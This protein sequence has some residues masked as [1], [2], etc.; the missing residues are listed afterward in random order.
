MTV[1]KFIV[2]FFD[3]IL[4]TLGVIVI[5]GLFAYGVERLYVFLMGRT[6]GRQSIFATA[7]IGVPIHELGHAA[8]C[9]VFGHR[10]TEIKLFNP[11]AEDGVFG[12]VKHRYNARNLYHQ[13]G[14][15][16]IG[17]GPIFSGVFVSSL[18]MLIC[19]RGA[20]VEYMGSVTGALFGTE[21]I[22]GAILH[23]LKMPI[24]MIVCDG[25]WWLKTSL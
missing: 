24:T 23:T 3:I 16:F 2:Y 1:L 11:R 7:I 9:L 18:I 17:L 12:Y 5:L 21:D 13:I 14:N 10:I 20:W 19:F 15:L 4:S 6:F 8:A 25:R 22:L